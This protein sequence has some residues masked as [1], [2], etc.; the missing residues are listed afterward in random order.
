MGMIDEIKKMGKSLLGEGD[1]VTEVVVTEVASTELPGT[2]LPGTDAPTTEMPEEFNTDAPG[3]DVPTTDAPVENKIDLM[4][5]LDLLRSEVKELKEP[6]PTQAPS[7]EA[8][9]DEQNFMEGIDLDDV[10][11]DPAEFN[12]LL[13]SVFKK[14]VQAARGEVR[15]GSETVI[16]SLPDI[17]SSNIKLVQ[18]LEKTSEDFYSDNK[19][20]LPYKENVSIVFGEVAVANPDKTYAE[21]LEL[22]GDEV[23]KRLNLTKPVVAE[24]K[25]KPPKLPTNKGKQRT[26]PTEQTGL[27]DEIDAMNKVL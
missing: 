14:G 19:D 22:V 17:V 24:T 16:S 27:A 23:R 8:P 12:K 5:E 11:R 1:V 9:I 25:K 2:E 7:T 18:A 13:N 6:T 15:L 20:L 26:T 3:T 10:T 21:N 4:A